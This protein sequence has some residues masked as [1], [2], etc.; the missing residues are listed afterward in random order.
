MKK[1]S[2]ADG[3][4]IKFFTDDDGRACSDIPES[5][6]REQPRNFN[7]HVGALALSKSA[8]GLIDPKLVLSWLVITLGGT[9]AMAGLLVP[10]REAGA[11]LPQLFTAGVIRRLPI[12]KYAWSIGSVL[13]G[14]AAIGIGITAMLAPEQSSGWIILGLLGM[15]ALAR[16]ICSVSYKDVLGKT[17]M[18]SRRGTA[19][20]LAGSLSSFFVIVFAL[21]LVFDIFARF[22]VIIAAIFIAGGLWLIAGLVFLRLEEEAG[23]VEGGQSSMK[24]AMKNIGLL[25]TNVQLNSFILVRALLTAT[26]LAPPFLVSSIG[27]Q[28]INTFGGLG[29]L[30]IASAMSALASSFIWGRI[31]DKSSRKVLITSAL[32]A[33]SSL[34]T[35][36]WAL[37]L[38]ALNGGI[39]LPI[40]LFTL[41]IAHQGVRLGRST[42]LVDMANEDTR[43]AYTALSNTIIGIVLLFGGLFSLVSATYGDV[44]VI[45]IMSFMCALAASFGLFLKE[46]Q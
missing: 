18:K 17:I 8:D 45:S 35:S 29:M 12:R 24:L 21:L 9:S 32:I 30:V 2:R 7:T 37:H 6:C 40:L 22:S 27:S 43:A 26:A 10:I 20:G 13:Q 23:A 44:V 46:V 4:L 11:L 39:L 31:A 16:S 1:E 42:H 25:K 41:M 28:D 34:A 3:A 36:A 33:A 14:L 38:G 15:L 19:T 5:A